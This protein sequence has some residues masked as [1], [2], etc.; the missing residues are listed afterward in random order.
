MKRLFFIL[1]KIKYRLIGIKITIKKKIKILIKT[2]KGKSNTPNKK[3]N[4]K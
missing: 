3:I 1:K 2:G 4:K